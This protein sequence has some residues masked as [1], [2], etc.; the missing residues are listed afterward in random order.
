MSIGLA[1]I[2]RRNGLGSTSHFESGAFIRSR[3]GIRW[4]DIQFHFLPLAIADG[5]RKPM[6]YHG[7]QIQ[8]G[9]MR[10]RSTGSVS[11]RV[12]STSTRVVAWPT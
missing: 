2:L 8:T 11:R 12:P 10:S 7:F 6:G 1:W 4:A 5:G 3:T 9:S